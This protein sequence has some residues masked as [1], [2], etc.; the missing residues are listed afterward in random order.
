MDPAYK[1]SGSSET[2]KVIQE[3]ITTETARA[4]EKFNL[5][6]TKW[7]KEILVIL[8]IVGISILR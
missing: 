8:A 2:I 5:F 4:Q 7:K 3:D 6:F 1:G